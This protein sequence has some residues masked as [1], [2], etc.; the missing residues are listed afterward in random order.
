MMLSSP[1]LC[2]KT[3]MVIPGNESGNAPKR[4]SMAMSEDLFPMSLFAESSQ[5]KDGSLVLL[6]LSNAWS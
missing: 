1:W 6:I 3:C 4:Y 5:G 2:L